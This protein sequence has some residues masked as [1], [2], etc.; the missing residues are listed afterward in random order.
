MKSEMYSSFAE[1]YFYFFSFSHFMRVWVYRNDVIIVMN[2]I[3]IM[4]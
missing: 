3:S 4:V 1:F 2:V